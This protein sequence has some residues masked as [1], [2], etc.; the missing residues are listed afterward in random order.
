MAALPPCVFR[1]IVT[2]PPLTPKPKTCDSTQEEKTMK[3]TFILLLA[4]LLAASALAARQVDI[5]HSGGTLTRSASG[6]TITDSKLI[7]VNN[8]YSNARITGDLGTVAFSTGALDSGS[9]TTGGTFGPGGSFT[10]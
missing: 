9:I 1:C 5:G 8:L 4:M 3:A 6:L 7:L 10:V 2:P